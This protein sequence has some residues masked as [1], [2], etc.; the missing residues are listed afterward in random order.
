MPTSE[1]TVKRST[2]AE[3]EAL[4]ASE[5]E[6]TQQSCSDLQAQMDND[7][8]ILNNMQDFPANKRAAIRA[9]I[10]KDL[11]TTLAQMKAQHCDIA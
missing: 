10:L 7:H 9:A 11:R 8:D 2:L 6:A 5:P 1:T 3:I 4:L